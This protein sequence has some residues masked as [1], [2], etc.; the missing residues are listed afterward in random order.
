M[1]DYVRDR[2]KPWAALLLLFCVFYIITDFVKSCKPHR[3]M[4]KSML[5]YIRDIAI[6]KDKKMERRRFYGEIQ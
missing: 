4:E 2:G 1:C 6:I 5:Q 3:G